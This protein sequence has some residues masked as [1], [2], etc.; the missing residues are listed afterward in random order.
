MQKAG[1]EMISIDFEFNGVSEPQLNL[2]CCVTRKYNVSRKW[3]L[4]KN[5][6][7]QQK[8]REY[9]LENRQETFISYAVEAEARSFLALNLDPLK[10]RWVDLYLEY[11][12]LL[13]HHHAY[14]YGEQLINNKIVITSPPKLY[15]E[16]DE[17]EDNSKPEYNLYA[18]IFKLL[19]IR[20][21]HAHKDTMRDLIIS[22]PSTFT[23]IEQESILN[24]CAED[25]AHLSDLFS[26]IFEIIQNIRSDYDLP[27][28]QY[29]AEYS[30]RTAKMVALGY[31]I[32]LEATKQFSKSV[33]AIQKT[34]AEDIN[35]IL[36]PLNPFT[37]D[38]SGIHLEQKQVQE[39]IRFQPYGKNWPRT[40]KGGISLAKDSFEKYCGSKHE[41]GHNLPDQMLRYMKLKQSLNGFLPAKGKKNFWDFVGSDGRVR[42]HFGI[43]G[44]QSS[45]SQPS[46]T[47]FIFLKS[48]WM[49]SLVHPRPGKAL[50]GVD[51]S[52][53]EF[54]I[55]AL[56][57]E[58]KAMQASYAS[59]DVYLDFAK[60]AGAIPEDATKKS[61]AFE[62][63][64]FKAIVLG[65]SYDLGANSMALKLTNDL[66]REFGAM[67]AQGLIDKFY[68]V[69]F[70]FWNWKQSIQAQYYGE[71]IGGE[72]FPGVGYLT[73]ADGWTMF[74]DNPNFRSVGNFPVQG[75]G[76]IIMRKAVEYAQNAG[77]KVIFTLHDAL[78]IEYDGF[79][80]EAVSLLISCM[81]KAF[82]FYFP[83]SGI[84]VEAESWATE[85]IHNSQTTLSCGNKCAL[86]KRHIDPRSIGDYIKFSEYIDKDLLEVLL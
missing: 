47:G 68:E 72:F 5:P 70:D 23:Q 84:R 17:G 54:L 20:L 21:D 63:N 16:K 55:S 12:M 34:C 4:H 80:F 53:Q 77:L 41:Y 50:A 52:S 11:R 66:G 8:L 31:P 83:K 30:C 2:V 78:Y 26:V 13:N 39:Y 42:P 32:N 33:P 76:A 45:R 65:L 38:V 3:W 48:A 46:S 9:L 29:R 67:Q 37:I 74:K 85:Y 35:N 24:Y 7:Q 44:S 51:Y 60:R 71:N 6:V 69:Y 28:I 82:D 15:E 1:I 81:V 59:G 43:F 10:F 58:D 14:A 49:R 18:A 73:L 79:D 36:F 27:E 86:Q 19:N 62:R 40:E 64:M 57:S 25:V 61:H 56:L 22:A 75:T